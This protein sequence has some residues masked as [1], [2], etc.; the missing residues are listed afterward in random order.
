M[1]NNSE[2]HTHD[3]EIDI[4]VIKLFGFVQKYVEKVNVSPLTSEKLEINV[5]AYGELGSEQDPDES[6]VFAR[7]GLEFP[8]SYS[9]LPFI[10]MFDAEGVALSVGALDF[11][12]SHYGH[13]GD[14]ERDIARKLVNILIG[15]ANGQLAVLN[16]ITQDDEKVQ[17]WEMLYRK[18]KESL[19]DA[20]VTYAAFDS[21]RKLK[22][23][24]MTTQKFAN[25]ADIPDVAVDIDIYKHFTYET[26]WL[27]KFNR[28]QIAGLHVPLTRDDWEKNVDTYYDEKSDA[29]IEKVD[30]WGK[31]DDRTLWQ[32]VTDAAKWRHLELMWWS[33]ALLIYVPVREWSLAALSP[34]AVVFGIFVIAATIFRRT[35]KF[36]R[37]YPHIRPLAYL[38]FILAT[39]V[40]AG[41]YDGSV[42]WFSLGVVAVLSLVENIFFDIREKIASK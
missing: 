40:F 20:I 10:M 8:K 26:E 32:Q 21:A 31:G 41:Q 12:Y 42:W 7:I 29:F 19:Y 22:D 27:N 14:S 9:D 23:R 15:L 38:G 36:Y 37:Y 2:P 11:V 5:D 30:K 17:A 35:P 39:V 25:N 33:L 28:T 16:T 3:E 18:P 6:V 24:E 4:S 13:L 1:V 34:S